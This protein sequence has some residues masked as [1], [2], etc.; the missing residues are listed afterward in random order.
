M[1]RVFTLI[2]LLATTAA[3]VCVFSTPAW[4]HAVLVDTE[5]ADGS[6]L[7]DSPGVIR[8]V[9]DEPVEVPLGA[10][11]VF[12]S[13]GVR[14]DRGDVGHGSG[15]EEV[16]VGVPELPTGAYLVTWRAV[17]ADSHPVSGA[18]LFQV[19][20]G[21][22]VVD[23]T[24]IEALLGGTREVP[25]AFAGLLL[26]WLTYGGGLIAAGGVV[27]GWVVTRR[28]VPQVVAL[29]RWAALVGVA[30]SLL[31]IPVFAAEATGLGWSALL[32]APAMRAALTSS[33]ALAAL[34]RVAALTWIAATVQKPSHWWPAAGVPG[35]VVAELATGHT[36]TSQPVWLVMGAD[37]VHVLFVAVWIGGLA[38]LALAMRAARDN[39]EVIWGARLVGRFSAMATWSMLGVSAGGL[40]L[41]WAL[42][43]TPQALI[44]TTYGWT[45]VAKTALVALVLVVAVYNNRVLVPAI[46]RS[47]QG[48]APE[49]AWRRLRRTVRVELVG[50]VVVVG[51][52][53]VLV[54]VQPA[55]EAAGVSGPYSTHVPFGD[56]ELNLVVDPNRAGSNEVH[57]FIRNPGGFS[58]LVTEPV[59]IEFR[60]PDREI[61][62]ITRTP[63]LAGIGHYLH[64]GPELAIPGEWE[65][66]VRQRVD[67]FE[68]VTAEVAVTVSR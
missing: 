56:L 39:D 54:N 58:A 62:P 59:E 2:R 24:L 45:L 36:R 31:Q 8:L 29:V 53:A 11:R 49:S 52:T 48:P 15:P 64:V 26:R 14:V 51:I 16:R 18:F 27:F 13:S 21:S 44:S 55:A 60:L 3:L 43:R 1:F 67:E 33:L 41:A 65:I 40:A 4:A 46:T 68:E 7:H 5:P 47:H 37:A 63:E 32:S 42:V 50:L 28:S 38:A 57:L 17:S 23:E 34:V 22:D 61:G 10:V 25:F 12:D 30:G 66:T 19:G 20:H 6:Q 9:F 35:V